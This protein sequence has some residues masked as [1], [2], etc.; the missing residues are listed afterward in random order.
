MQKKH[1][2]DIANIVTMPSD[3][4]RYK[5]QQARNRIF[6]LLYNVAYTFIGYWAV[7]AILKLKDRW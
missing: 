4:S 2:N 3:D 6:V 7:H 5:V 1:I